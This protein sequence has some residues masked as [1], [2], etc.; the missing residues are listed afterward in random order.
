MVTIKQKN[1]HR[2]NENVLKQAYKKQCNRTAVSSDKMAV[3]GGQTARDW[4]D[5]FTKQFRSM[6]I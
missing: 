1:T 6:V 2:F 4:Y 5:D 3:A